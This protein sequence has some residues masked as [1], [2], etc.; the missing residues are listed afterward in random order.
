MGGGGGGVTGWGG[1]RSRLLP[2][3]SISPTPTP[4]F[5]SFQNW[6]D[7]ESPFSHTANLTE[8][9][10][11][12]K[13]PPQQKFTLITHACK[14]HTTAKRENLPPCPQQDTR[15]L[16]SMHLATTQHAPA[17]YPARH[18]PTAQH[19][20]GRYPA[21]TWP[22]EPAV[23]TSTST[24]KKLTFMLT[25]ASK[26][27]LENKNKN[28]LTGKIRK[29]NLIN[30]QSINNPYPAGSQSEEPFKDEN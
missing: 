10:R 8:A 12:S 2:V 5:L 13:P 4:S 30:Q 19:A 29:I 18:L 23:P 21:C 3:T 9:Q 1:G 24:E 26:T 20:P 27:L 7:D 28:H 15:P 11:D 22:L 17:H 14:R 25:H 6:G 16:P